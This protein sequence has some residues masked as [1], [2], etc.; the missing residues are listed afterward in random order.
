MRL[1]T[2]TL[3]VAA[4]AACASNQVRSSVDGP[5]VARLR[6]VL[7]PSATETI[8]VRSDS[9]ARQLPGVTC[10]RATRAPRPL[11]H[12]EDAR[13]RVAAM[14]VTARDTVLVAG[15]ADLTPAWQ[16][17]SAASRPSLS[18][19]ASSVTAL[20]RCTGLVFEGELISSSGQVKSKAPRQAFRDSSAVDAVVP[21]AIERDESA[22]IVVF[23]ASM[24]TGLYRYRARI[25]DRSGSLTVTRELLSALRMRM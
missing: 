10:L 7:Q 4:L 2:I 24:P 14:V 21:P 12:A 3:A 13:P 19:L 23:Y 6:D 18:D 11:A 22:A 9:T 16:A 8:A 20:S 25:D 15:L 1:P 17:V 5:I